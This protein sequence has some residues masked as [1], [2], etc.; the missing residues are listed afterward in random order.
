MPYV[1]IAGIFFFQF[2]LYTCED[3]VQ[4]C[5]QSNVNTGGECAAGGN[6]NMLAAASSVLFNQ[7]EFDDLDCHTVKFSYP[8]LFYVIFLTQRSFPSVRTKGLRSSSYIR[9]NLV[10]SH[11]L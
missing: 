3:P 6:I 1:F 8:E 7:D 5:E 9:C 10:P 2:C 11:K 4:H